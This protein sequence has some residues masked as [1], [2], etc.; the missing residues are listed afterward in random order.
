MRKGID[1]F[2]VN[3]FLLKHVFNV[4]QACQHSMLCAPWYLKPCQPFMATSR[5][6]TLLTAPISLVPALYLAHEAETGAYVAL[7]CLS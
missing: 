7:L 6:Q 5:W 3:S 1:Y 2:V 4:F